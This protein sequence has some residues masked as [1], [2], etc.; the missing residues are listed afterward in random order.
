MTRRWAIFAT[1]VGILCLVPTVLVT[2]AYYRHIWHYSWVEIGLPLVMMT[3]VYILLLTGPTLV[4]LS[5]LLGLRYSP[6]QS[7]QVYALIG[8]ALTTTYSLLGLG[9]WPPDVP[10]R[11]VLGCMAASSLAVLVGTLRRRAH[12]KGIGVIA[13]RR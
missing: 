11:V 13:Q 10:V 12:L 6:Q 3:G 9:V 7:V 1:G 2:V 5:G 8:S 4:T